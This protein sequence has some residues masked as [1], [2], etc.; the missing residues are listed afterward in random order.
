M[1]LTNSKPIILKNSEAQDIDT[2][3]DWSLAELK[4]SKLLNEKD[5]TV[6]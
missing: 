5:N 3:D 6:C 4:Y 2:Y 1:I